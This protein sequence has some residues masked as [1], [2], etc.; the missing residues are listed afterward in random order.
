MLVF[1]NFHRK[2]FQRFILL[3]FVLQQTELV[4]TNFY[5]YNL[6]SFEENSQEIKYCLLSKVFSQIFQKEIFMLKFGPFCLIE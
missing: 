5:R 4:Q 3:Q 6:G 2:V 1:Q